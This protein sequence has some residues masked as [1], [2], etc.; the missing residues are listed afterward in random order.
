M[1][2]ALTIILTAFLCCLMA[3]CSTARSGKSDPKPGSKLEQPLGDYP[4]LHEGHAIILG[5]ADGCESS[6]AAGCWH[7]DR[8]APGVERPTACVPGTR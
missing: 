3:G 8:C 4:V 1:N 2:V 6:P 7:P 5:P